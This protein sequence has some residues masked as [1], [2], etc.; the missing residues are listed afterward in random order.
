MIL[1]TPHFR[2]FSLPAAFALSLISPHAATHVTDIVVY[3]GTSAGVTAAVAAAREG[4]TV[5]LVEPGRHLGGM[6]SG[7]LGW[8]DFGTQSAIGGMAREFYQLIGAKY[9]TTI[10]W[11]FEPHVAESVFNEM[12]RTAGVQIFLNKRLVENTGTLKNGTSISQITVEDGDIFQARVFLDATYEGDLM[13]QAGVSYTWGRE[14]GAQYGESLAGVRP[15]T[16]KHQFPAG[17][18]PY[19]LGLPLQEILTTPRGIVGSGDQKV[20][21]YNYRLCMTDNAANRT[22]FVMP[23][24]YDHARYQLLARYINVLTAAAGGV[25]PPLTTVA[26]LDIIFGRKTDTNN[27]GGY[28]TDYIGHS[29]EYPEATYARRA[30]L[31]AEHKD[32]LMGFWYFLQND[33]W[34]PQA[35][36]TSALTWGLARDEFTDNGNWPFQLYVREARRMIGEY[37][38]IQP[39]IQT[40]RTKA[41]GVGM[42]SYNSDSHHVQ[43]IIN[44]SGF[45]ENEGDMQVAVQPY[46]IPYRILTP[47][48]AQATNLLVPVCFSASHVTYSTLRMEPQY[49]ILGQAAG[50]A[51][52][53]TFRANATV[54]TID[55]QALRSRLA[56]LGANL[57]STPVTRV[58]LTHPFGK[59]DQS[60]QPFYFLINGVK[61]F[62]IPSKQP[63]LTP[64]HL[65]PGTGG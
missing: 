46:E 4:A 23:V 32:Y 59:S 51:A 17:L 10:R 62:G 57:G 20:Q 44:D 41:E 26:K 43:R 21:A 3:G 61:E 49:M 52:V 1:M 39:D 47:R 58:L 29:W 9:A 37:V 34:L 48:R 5:A 19:Y 54:Q 36:R 64:V 15:Y 56:A 8:T 22:P 27:N 2:K 25:A 14:A 50:I 24:N 30:Q 33:A 55:V 38:M 31:W 63:I 6:T 18:D 65:A 16:N 7:G 13:A 11:T 28:S 40:V 45:V 53:M 12:S 42:G 35:I 60:K